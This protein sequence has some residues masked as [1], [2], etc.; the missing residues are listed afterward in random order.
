MPDEIVSISARSNVDSLSAERLH[1]AFADLVTHT[2]SESTK[3]LRAIEPKDTG[4]LEEHTSHSSTVEDVV[5]LI[6][7]RLGIA[8]IGESAIPGAGGTAISPRFDF[9]PSDTSHYPLFVDQGT[10]V[11]G[12][13]HTPIFARSGGAMH[14]EIDGHQIFARSVAGQRGQHFMAATFAYAQA[15]LHTDP[16]IRLALAEMNAE[17]AARLAIEA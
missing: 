14:F 10:G 7:A 16:Q 6:E 15:L 4:A 17:A 5:N 9:E 12:Q 2:I 11:F 1:R 13:T 8:A 3:F